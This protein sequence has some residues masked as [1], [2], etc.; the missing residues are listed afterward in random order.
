MRLGN[1]GE[2]EPSMMHYPEGLPGLNPVQELPPSG[3]RETASTLRV[4]GRL[5]FLDGPLPRSTRL[6]LSQLDA[7]WRGVCST[8]QA[9]RLPRAVIN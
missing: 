8:G 4:D 5:V 1:T 2:M 6:R 9:I 3:D 7:P